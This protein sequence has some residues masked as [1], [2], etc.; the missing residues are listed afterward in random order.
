MP[1]ALYIYL[2][3]KPSPLSYKPIFLPQFYLLCEGWVCRGMRGKVTLKELV[4]SFTY[5]MD[6]T[7][8]LGAARTF[9]W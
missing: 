4:L 2:F 6:Q 9:P 1:Q 5:D 7:Q 3:S 8:V